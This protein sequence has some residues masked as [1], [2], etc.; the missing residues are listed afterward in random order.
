M[1]STCPPSTSPLFH[2]AIANRKRIP[3]R[4]RSNIAP[5][6][7]RSV[8]QPIRRRGI[9]DFRNVAWSHDGRGRQRHEHRMPS[10]DGRRR[11]RRMAHRT[12]G[13]QYPQTTGI[14]PSVRVLDRRMFASWRRPGTV[15]D[16][17]R[18]GHGDQG[19]RR[20]AMQTAGLEITPRLC[21]RP[22][23][24]NAT[25]DQ[26]NSS[27]TIVV[28]SPARWADH[29]GIVKPIDIAEH[30]RRLVLVLNC[31]GGKVTLSSHRARP[32]VELNDGGGTDSSSLP[33][34]TV[35]E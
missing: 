23:E 9:N 17:S 24:L 32:G 35:Q 21:T 10:R 5:R 8:R 12:P 27:V 15:S 2:T 26:R 20:Q 11:A 30:E 25:T 34:F 19:L 1:E 13:R 14:T 16:A 18:T 33:G 28:S 3:P 7:R 6:T 29:R 4:P 31:K 22:L